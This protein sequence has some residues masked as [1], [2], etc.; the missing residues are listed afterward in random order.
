MT[1]SPT[2]RR[3]TVRI[4]Q[5]LRNTKIKARLSI[6]APESDDIQVWEIDEKDLP[7]LSRMQDFL[8]GSPARDRKGYSVV[9][10]LT[11]SDADRLIE[12]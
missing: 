3:E 6:Y 9:E 7:R 4:L 10:I 8:R 12:R 11:G 5:R 2:T 1:R